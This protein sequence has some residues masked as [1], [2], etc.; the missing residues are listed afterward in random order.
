VAQSSRNCKALQNHISHQKGPESAGIPQEVLGA[1][2]SMKWRPAKTNKDQQSFAWH[3]REQPLTLSQQPTSQRSA[4]AK[5]HV[6]SHVSASEKYSL[7]YLLQKNILLQ[8]SITR[9]N[10]VSKETRNF[11]FILEMLEP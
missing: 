9:H 3:C 10:Q 5:H 8:G 1:F 4:P 6:L 11:H 7:M 2:I